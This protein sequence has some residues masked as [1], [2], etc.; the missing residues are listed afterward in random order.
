MK[1]ADKT[2]SR[3]RLRVLDLPKYIEFALRYPIDEDDHKKE[4]SE[5]LRRFLIG[6]NGWYS[7]R[8]IASWFECDGG[9]FKSSQ[10]DFDRELKLLNVQEKPLRNCEFEVVQKLR[11]FTNSIAEIENIYR[12]ECDRRAFREVSREIR[13]A[14]LLESR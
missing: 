11:L 14:K 5:D 9:F 10:D 8:G 3:T 7:L 13:K 1:R 2:R 6:R 4:A 12:D